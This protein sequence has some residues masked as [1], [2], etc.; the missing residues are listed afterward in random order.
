MRVVVQDAQL[1]AVGEVIGGRVDADR[2]AVR[3]EPRFERG[4]LR[5]HVG[6]GLAAGQAEPGAPPPQVHRGGHDL[7]AGQPDRPGDVRPGRDGA[8]PRG[9]SRGAGGWPTTGP[10]APAPPMPSACGSGGASGADRGRQRVPGAAREHRHGHVEPFQPR[11]DAEPRAEGGQHPRG[12][13]GDR[14]G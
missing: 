14:R 5:H 4:D 11:G 8:L 9:P 3:A 6:D 7:R 13:A 12:D 10:T 1:A 2:V